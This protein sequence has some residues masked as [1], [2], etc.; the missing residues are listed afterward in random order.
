MKYIPP[1]FEK[2]SEMSAIDVGRVTEDEARLILEK[3]RWPEGIRCAHCGSENVTR[4]NSK[5][6]KTRD[7]VL[8][9]N[10]CRKQFAVMEYRQVMEDSDITLRQWLRHFIQ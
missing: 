7:G 6:E 8:Q 9:C 5:S 2:F 4:I 1:K 3:I 10:A